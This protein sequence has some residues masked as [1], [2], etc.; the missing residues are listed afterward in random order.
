MLCA[1]WK[2][3]TYHLRRAS[4]LFNHPVLTAHAA[5]SIT[6]LIVNIALADDDGQELCTA[7]AGITDKS[8][9]TTVGTEHDSIECHGITFLLRLGF[10]LLLVCSTRAAPHRPHRHGSPHHHQ[11]HRRR[12]PPLPRYPTQKLSLFLPRESIS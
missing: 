5:N 1:L 6:D 8:T 11:P 3:S 7:I 4:N 10:S 2:T 9:D 12:A